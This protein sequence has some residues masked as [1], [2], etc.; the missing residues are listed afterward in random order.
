MGRDKALLDVGGR[1]L[2]R[3]A[4]DALTEAGASEVYAVG[5]DLPALAA[6]GLDGVADPR[7]GEGPLGGLVTALE[8]ARSDV[9]VVL[10]CDLPRVTGQ[11]VSAVLAGLGDDADVAIPLVDGRLQPLLAAWRRPPAL[12]ALVPAFD[13]GERAIWRAMATLRRHE[14]TL[15]ASSWADDAD[16][17]DGALGT[18]A[19]G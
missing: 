3:V 11:A 17:P 8:V 2:A 14:I 6:A 1:V 12:A 13:S 7:Q 9:V 15:S 19:S 18:E 10:A 5:G 4:A 16:H